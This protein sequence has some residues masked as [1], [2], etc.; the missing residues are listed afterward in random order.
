MFF[1][2]SL[3]LAFALVFTASSHA[4]MKVGTAN[5]R[6]I[7]DGYYKTKQ[8]DQMLKDRAAEA[9]KI[10]KDMLDDYQK[11]SEAYKTLSAGAAD[12]A[13]S[14]D[15]R[16][17][18]KKSAEQ[19]LLELQEIEKQVQQYRKNNIQALEDQKRRMREDVLRNIRERITTKAKAGGYN[20]VLDLSAETFNQTDVFLF[21]SG[22]TDLTEEVLSDLNANA[23]AALLKD[24]KPSTEK[25]DD[26]K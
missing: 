19:K 11:A 6:K 5:V 18:R 10:L 9:E 15:E 22:L 24:E 12:Q 8:A 3:A 20:L 23:P 14:S 4:Q 2:S 1:R 16:D 13:V 7:F 17:K 21:S 26:K 25:R